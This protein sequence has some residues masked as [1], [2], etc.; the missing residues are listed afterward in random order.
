MRVVQGESQ[1]SP[2][3]IKVGVPQGSVLSPLLWNI[4]INDL[5]YLVHSTRAFM[6]DITVSFPFIPGEEALAT[7][8]LDALLHRIED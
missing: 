2:N 5:L 1:S 6:D 8:S 3:T 7:T 4:F